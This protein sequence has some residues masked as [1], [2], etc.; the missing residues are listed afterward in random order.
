[1]LLT[2]AFICAFAAS[3]QQIA[4]F[5]F[6]CKEGVSHELADSIKNI[7]VENF[8]PEGC[9]IEDSLKVAEAVENHGFIIDSMM[10]KQFVRVGRT[11][12]M[13]RVVVGNISYE[14]DFLVI[15]ISLVNVKTLKIQI[16]IRAKLK[17]MDELGSVM[18]DIAQRIMTRIY[19]I[20]EEEMQEMEMMMAVPKVITVKGVT[21]EM[22]YVKGGTYVMG[23]TAEQGT[24][25]YALEKPAH[26]VTVDDFYIAKFEVTQGLWKA[27]MGSEP[28]NDG[29]WT[30]FGY[31]DNYPAYRVS[32]KDCQV[33]IKKLNE[34]TGENFRMPYE[35]EWEY[36][37]RGGAKSRGYRFSGSNSINDVAW[38]TTNTFDT[39]CQPVGTKNPNELGLYDM[40]G[41]VW[42]WCYD[43]Y[44]TYEDKWIKNPK[45]KATGTNKVLRGGSWSR[46]SR[47]C[48]VSNRGYNNPDARFSYNGLR[49][50]LPVV[51]QDQPQ[52]V[53]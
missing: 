2:A 43:W 17:N 24:E 12:G 31:G 38:Y 22:I 4:V 10:K 33:F 30:G 47:L 35:A 8:H 20:R 19:V 3:A 51:G 49:L 29:G 5:D 52:E 44:G 27:V 42:E 15:A 11:L 1:M 18:S 9:V 14:E 6:K 28:Q 45:G 53:E 36:A 41:N 32:W 34:L 7:F 37:A 50:L 26:K 25:A 16:K 48:R 13:D 40:S 46:G 21:F 39:G 23:G